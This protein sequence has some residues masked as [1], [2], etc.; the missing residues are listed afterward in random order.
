MRI[1]QGFP[2][3]GKLSDARLTD[4]VGGT[5]E[6]MPLSSDCAPSGSG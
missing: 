6:L 2:Y 5:I 1:T 4:E 3:E